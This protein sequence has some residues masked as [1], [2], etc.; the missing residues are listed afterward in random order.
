SLWPS[1]R[2]QRTSPIL[3]RADFRFDLGALWRRGGLWRMEIRTPLHRVGLLGLAVLDQDRHHG[4]RFSPAA[5]PGAIW[6]RAEDGADCPRIARHNS[7]VLDRASIVCTA[8]SRCPDD[9]SA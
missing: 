3:R 5:I 1:A 9:L 4:R 6:V 7:C 2:A 8:Q